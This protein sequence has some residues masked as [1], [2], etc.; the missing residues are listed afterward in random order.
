MVILLLWL[1]YYV[2]CTVFCI[3]SSTSTEVYYVKFDCVYMYCMI[4]LLYDY[5]KYPH[6]SGREG[7]YIST[8][9]FPEPDDFYPTVS[10]VSF[11][12]FVCLFCMVIT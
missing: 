5:P 9:G 10:K 8:L 7:M 6:H 11:D 1:T 12:L 2:V 4:T 3:T